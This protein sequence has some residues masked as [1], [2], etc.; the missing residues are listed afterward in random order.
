MKKIDNQGMRAC[1]RACMRSRRMGTG[2]D[3][4]SIYIHSH[5]LGSGV[6]HSTTGLLEEKREREKE[7]KYYKGNKETKH[8]YTTYFVGLFEVDSCWFY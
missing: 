7:K 3:I 1:M 8:Y 4:R 5:D 6:P 2:T